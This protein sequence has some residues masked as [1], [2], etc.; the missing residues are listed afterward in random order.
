VGLAALVAILAV[1]GTV[2]VV[3]IGTSPEPVA[4]NVNPSPL[5]YTF[6]LALFAAPCAVLGLWVWRSPQTAEQ[7]VGC[8]L[9]LLSIIPVGFILDLFFGRTFLTFPNANATLGILIPGYDLHSGL[10]GL[11]GPGWKRYLPLE[12][13]VFY[14]LGFVAILLAYVWGD[15]IL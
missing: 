2:A 14:A 5:G 12:E 7:R 6:S 10:P 8:A 4:L 3:Q 13:F 11:W 1:S 9:T 15:E